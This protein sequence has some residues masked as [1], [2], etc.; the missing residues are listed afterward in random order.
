MGV[1]RIVPLTLGWEELPKSVSVH[2]ASKTERLREPVPGLLL[3]VDGG[4]LLLDTGFNT[5]LIRDPALA[6]RFFGNP[7]YRPVLPGPGEPLEEALDAEGIDVAEIYAV[8]VS[9]LHVDHAGG[10][11]LFAGRVPVHAQRAEVAY[12]M[13]NHPE[14]ERHA[15]MRIDYD[16]PAIDWRLADGD[17]EIAPG[18]TAVLTAG[19]TPGHQSFVVELDPSVGGGGF[20]FAFDAADLTENLEEELAVGSFIGV[21]AE[22][23]VEPIRRL[24]G[25]AA[26]R[27]YRL[28]PGH[29][30][31]AWPAL[32]SELKE[33]FTA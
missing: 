19:H 8:A 12:G 1:R 30:P 5:A 18:V 11:K 28:V 10:L 7:A 13:S 23:T 20:V 32:T 26:Q 27:G 21:S 15:M 22:E 17:T 4:W 31:V 33:R 3:Q 2:G 14:P 6:R 29:D 24:K 16:D 25:I 9:H